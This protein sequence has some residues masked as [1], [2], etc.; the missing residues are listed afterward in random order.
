MSTMKNPNK[1]ARAIKLLRL[2]WKVEWVF[3]FLVIPCPVLSRSIVATYDK[4][5]LERDMAPIPRLK[6]KI[7]AFNEEWDKRKPDAPNEEA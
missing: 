5:Q 4:E 3:L 7:K 2:H 6:E 1:L